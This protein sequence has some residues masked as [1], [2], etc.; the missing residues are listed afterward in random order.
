MA[1]FAARTTAAEETHIGAVAH[2]PASKLTRLKRRD[3]QAWNDVF[4]E[5]HVLVFRAVLAQ[6]RDTTVAEDITAQVFLEALQGIDRYRDRGKPIAAWLTTIARNRSTDWLRKQRREQRALSREAALSAVGTS[7]TLPGDAYAL[8]DPLTPE[9][10]E[11]VALRFIEELSLEEVASVTGRSPGAVKSLQHRALRQL[12]GALT[13]TTPSS[14][15][16]GAD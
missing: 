5:H 7:E 15:T 10:R 11:V 4:E 13:A 2:T 3:A 16:E 8:L 1:Y 9:Q 12:R 6:V 14:P